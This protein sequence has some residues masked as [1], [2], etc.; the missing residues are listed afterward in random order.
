LVKFL[1]IFIGFIHADHL[2]K[3]L[4]S[5]S[6]EEKIIGR[7]IYACSNPPTLFLSEKHRTLQKYEPIR[8]LYSVVSKPESLKEIQN[9]YLSSE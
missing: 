4:S 6:V 7:I 8:D 5:Y 2:T 3:S 1:K 9:S